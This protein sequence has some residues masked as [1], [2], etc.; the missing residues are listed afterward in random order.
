MTEVPRTVPPE[1]FF[2]QSAF[3]LASMTFE[4]EA[5]SRKRKRKPTRHRACVIGVV[6]CAVGFLESAINRFYEAALNTSSPTE[7]DRALSGAWNRVRRQPVLAKYFAA[8][9]AAKLDGFQKREEPYASARALIVLR[10]S[11]AHTNNLTGQEGG[12]KRLESKLRRRY[13]F[14]S[15][16]ERGAEFF[17]ERCL[18]PDCSTWAVIAAAR[19]FLEFRRRLPPSA[20]RAHPLPRGV[21]AIL[22]KAERLRGKHEGQ[23]RGKRA[24]PS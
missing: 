4:E 19:F 5:K 17:P 24:R 10:N 11:I 22:A 15:R 9:A 12:G 20:Y 1:L 3:D 2:L 13:A 18:S 21:G 16:R 14:E 6:T 23:S 8:L 7:F